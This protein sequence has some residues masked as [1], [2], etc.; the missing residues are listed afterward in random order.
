MIFSIILLIVILIILQ[1]IIGH[2]WHDVG[3]NYSKS[4]QLMF[5]P[6]GIGLFIMQIA[7]YERHYPNWDVPFKVK[8]RLKYMYISTFFEYV[9]VYLF[10]LS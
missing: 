5:L 1:L 10:R 6:L 8:L 9:A 7:Y 3:F 4:I 2:F